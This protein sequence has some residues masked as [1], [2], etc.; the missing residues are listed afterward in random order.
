[1]AYIVKFK[2]KF[3]KNKWTEQLF[4]FST[5]A[6]AERNAKQLTKSEKDDK[7]VEFKTVAKA[8][9]VDKKKAPYN[10]MVSV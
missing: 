5:K 7:G 3:T 10:K 2:N 4:L 8:V 9:K 6:K 1:M